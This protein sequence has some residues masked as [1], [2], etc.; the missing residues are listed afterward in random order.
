MDVAV[1]PVAWTVTEVDGT[2]VSRWQDPPVGTAG[3]HVNSGRPG[4]GTNIVISGHHN[5]AGQVFRDLI[6]L[7]P[8][9]IVSLWAQG[10]RYDYVVAEKLILPE[11]GV[12]QEQRLQNASWMQPTLNE[13]LTLITCWPQSSNTHRLVIWARPYP[14]APVASL[15]ER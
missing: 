14:D 10:R 4:S 1:V 15:A 12:P 2:M 8:G 3:W 9:Q 6:L 5:I 7:E 13:R 11:Q